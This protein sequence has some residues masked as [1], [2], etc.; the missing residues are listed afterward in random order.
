VRPEKDA[1]SAT[2]AGR[3]FGLSLKLMR[4]QAHNGVI[5]ARKG[6]R[7]RFFRQAE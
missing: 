7:R 5:P 3:F 4:G 1:L 2:E 6:G